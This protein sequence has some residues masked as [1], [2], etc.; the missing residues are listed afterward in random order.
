MDLKILKE[1][2]FLKLMAGIA[3]LPIVG[4]FL[5]PEVAK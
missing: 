1:D 5:K 3:S 4:K 2:Y